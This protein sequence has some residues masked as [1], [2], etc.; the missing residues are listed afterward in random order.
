[1]LLWT[2][3]AALELVGQGGFGY[4][5]DA[6]A[7]KHNEFAEAI[8][9]LKYALL[10]LSS[11]VNLKVYFSQP[12]FRSAS[13]RS[14][15]GSDAPEDCSSRVLGARRCART[16]AEHPSSIRT[17]HDCRATRDEPGQPE[18]GRACARRRVDGAPG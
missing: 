6:L 5:F 12:G 2:G 9:A 16:G 13:R 8:K 1:M 3:R 11:I 14:P 18:E 7:D 15:A 17:D 10:R 4:S